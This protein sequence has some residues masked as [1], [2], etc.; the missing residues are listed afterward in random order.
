[1][2]DEFLHAAPHTQV[3]GLDGLAKGGTISFSQD[4]SYQISQLENTFS[5]TE[6][7]NYQ[8]PQIHFGSFPQDKSV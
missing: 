6:H 7:T 4:I 2:L 1:M 5:L 3:A 8:D